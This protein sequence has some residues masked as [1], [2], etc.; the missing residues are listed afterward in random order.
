MVGVS[1]K[2]FSENPALKN[3]LCYKRYQECVRMTSVEIGHTK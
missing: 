3:K 1:L 2:W